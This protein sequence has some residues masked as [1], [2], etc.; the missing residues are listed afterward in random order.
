MN[1]A[2]SVASWNMK[3]LSTYGYLG[4][5]G[6]YQSCT[7]TIFLVEIPMVLSTERYSPGGGGG[8]G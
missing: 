2:K 4:L 7:A 3:G 5:E 8:G 1:S 6:L